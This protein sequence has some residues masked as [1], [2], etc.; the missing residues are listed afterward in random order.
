MDAFVQLALIEKA[1][2]VF[3]PAGSTFLSFPLLSPLNYT[4]ETLSALAAPMTVADYEYAADFSR[5]VNFIARDMVANMSDDIYLWDVYED[6]LSRAEV[7][8]SLSDS[9]SDDASES[10]LYCKSPDGSKIESEAYRVYRQYRDAW[11][12][13]TEDYKS[14]QLTGEWSDDPQLASQWRESQ[15]PALRAAVTAA[16]EAWETLGQRAAIDSAVAVELANGNRN[17]S[18]RFDEWKANF[19]LDIDTTTA[20]TSGSRFPATALSPRD[21][22]ADANW[23]QFELTSG[24]MASLVANAPDSLKRVLDDSAGKDIVH[25]AFEYRSVA[26]IRPWFHSEA[27]TSRLWR[28]DDPELALSDGAEHP[29]GKCPGYATAVI[30]I[31][32]LVIQ[33]R[34][35]VAVTPKE[36]FRFTLPPKLL[37]TRAL[38]PISTPSISNPQSPNTM[39]AV[40]N[41]STARIFSR[42]ASQALKVAPSSRGDIRMSKVVL[43]HR[44]ANLTLPKGPVAISPFFRDRTGHHE[45]SGNSEQSTPPVTP[46]NP[47]G[48][49]TLPSKRHG[50]LS[51]LAFI[52]KRLPRAPDPLPSLKWN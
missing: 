37:T 50:E 32:N 23:L 29:T 11:I 43:S 7:A 44:S 3:T 52:C 49:L 47:A 19:N 28:S 13:A 12:V 46:P 51:V 10:L 38:I 15:E 30:F 20:A 16:L 17:P 45:D 5:T 9:E 26:L 4:A 21:F 34:K 1:K 2:R 39:P 33:K 24:E 8:N 35:A 22:V 48:V 40:V 25:V 42:I 6:V 18:R 27:L 41:A 14:H 36:G 31:R